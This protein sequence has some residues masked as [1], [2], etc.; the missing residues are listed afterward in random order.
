[1]LGLGGISRS[2]KLEGSLRIG[3]A[4]MVVAN[5]MQVFRLNRDDAGPSVRQAE[6]QS[7][8]VFSELRPSRCAVNAAKPAST[9]GD[10]GGKKG[11]Q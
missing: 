4:E 1:M 10:N 5:F 8:D 9:G 11:M 7:G 6:D 3:V 2:S